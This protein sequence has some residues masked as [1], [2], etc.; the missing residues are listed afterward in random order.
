MSASFSTVSRIA[1]KDLRGSAR[2]FT[3]FIFSLILGV[4]AIA[5]IGLL[6]SSAQRGIA[7]NADSLLGGDILVRTLY[8]PMSDEA[9][10][11][12]QSKGNTLEYAGLR[13]MARVAT[14]DNNDPQAINSQIAELKAVPDTYPL[15][16]EFVTQPRMDYEALYGKQ[17]NAYGTAVEQELLDVLNLSLG[18]NIYVGEQLF[19]IR[20]VITSEPDRLGANYSLGPRIMIS[21]DAL[22]DTGLVQYGSLI[23][24][25]MLL[26]AD[27]GINVAA[28]EDELMNTYNN[29]GFQMR[30]NNDAAP[31]LKRA[32]DRLGMF[33][34]FAA[35]STL[36]IGGVGIANATKNYLSTRLLSVARLK[37]LG[38]TQ[39]D[40]LW[41]YSVQLCILC[42]SSIIIAIILAIITHQTILAVFKESLP[43]P[44]DE[45]LSFFPLIIATAYGTLT[46]ILFAAPALVSAVKTR[47]TTLLRYS[48]V[49]H[50][51]ILHY[52]PALITL[53]IGIILGIIILTVYF[54]NNLILSGVFF[55]AFIISALIF[56]VIAYGIKRICQ[57]LSGKRHMSVS[58]RMALKNLSRTG[59]ITTS[60]SISLGLSLTLMTALAII[61]LNFYQQL[62]YQPP[63]MAPDFFLI[64]V[65]PSQYDKLNADI[66]SK[67]GVTSLNLTPMIRGRITKLND[68]PLTADMVDPK[69]RWA[70]QGERGITFRDAPPDNNILTEGTWWQEGYEGEPLVS[71]GAEL[72]E[73]MGIRLNDKLTFNVLGRNI[74]ARV[75]SLRDINWTTLQMNFGI[76]LSPNALADFTPMY[77]GTVHID[78]A[79]EMDVLRDLLKDYPS[80]SVIRIKETLKRVSG[81]FGSVAL[82]ILV[83]AAL[84][85]I[86]GIFVIFGSLGSSVRSRAYESMLLNVLGQSR[87]SI[88]GII[89]REMSWLCIVG[90]GFALLLGTILSYTLADIMRLP[91][92]LFIPEIYI[93]ALIFGV[94]LIIGLSQW[95]IRV[96]SASRPI[97]FLRNE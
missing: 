69:V 39:K 10:A 24:Y 20:A 61:A 77:I 3:I 60:F 14:P 32:L 23:N 66:I 25:V 26:R 63:E 47:A 83:V 94:I 9:K 50:S 1:I 34:T 76:I 96:I 15:A 17:N 22:Q 68:A 88:R 53:L 79:Y 58:N 93:G 57:T 28:V 55:C 70:L 85:I 2:H 84:T 6:L 86:A 36:L 75:A 16:G 72:A 82:L 8:N 29:G 38:A 95:L 41:I 59:A 12:M 78:D 21:R 7:N 97:D 13:T 49:Q 5:T 73:G 31:G 18:D 62:R 44:A 56:W 35:L 80:I 65:Q 19:A 91:T 46:T 30:T 81:L 45:N 87:Q 48:A 37:C 33:L 4:T 52:S 51:I 89:L 64:D 74:T 42:I 71:F 43:I 90:I 54:V 67:Q 11:Y 92:W 27:E 40:V